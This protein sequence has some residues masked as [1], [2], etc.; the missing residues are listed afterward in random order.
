MFK[1]WPNTELKDAWRA[2]V[3]DDNS[4]SRENLNSFYIIL[5]ILER[6]TEQFVVRQEQ[7]M[8]KKNKAAINEARSGPEAKAATVVASNQRGRQN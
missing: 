7:K 6:I 4:L 3:E 1:F 2:Y 5:R 8:E